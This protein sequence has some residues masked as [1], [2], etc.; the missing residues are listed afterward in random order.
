MSEWIIPI[1]VGL[2]VGL[3]AAMLCTLIGLFLPPIYLIAPDREE[4]DDA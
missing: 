2:A 1:A 3:G 4:D